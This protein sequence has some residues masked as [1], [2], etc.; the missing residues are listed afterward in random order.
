MEGKKQDKCGLQ[1]TMETEFRFKYMSNL[2]VVQNVQ[3][4]NMLMVGNNVFLS[5]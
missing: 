5:F 4:F 1:L 2:W 3:K